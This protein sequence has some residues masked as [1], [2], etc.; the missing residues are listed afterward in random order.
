MIKKNTRVIVTD[1]RGLGQP[2][3]PGDWKK[4]EER[5]E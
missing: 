1:E 2:A 3:C 5:S 4:Y